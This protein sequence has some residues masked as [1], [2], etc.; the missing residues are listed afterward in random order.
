MHYFIDGYNLLFRLMNADE[1]LQTKREQIII[2]LNAK[3][4]FAKIELSIVFDA[5]YQMGDRTRSHFDHI[6]ILFTAQGESADE[7]I[8]DEIKNSK[9][10]NQETVVT[11][12][13]T[14]AW[15]ARRLS[16]HSQSIES[17]ISWLNKL[18]QKKSKEA[19]YPK[20]TVEPIKKIF[21]VG[22]GEEKK[23]VASHVPSQQAS[24]GDCLEYYERV[25]EERYQ[26]NLKEEKP[27]E[28]KARKVPPR[29]K[30]KK[31]SPFETESSPVNASD[32]M[33]R[34][35]QIFE[36]KIKDT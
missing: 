34:W 10:P 14:L 12:D 27:K 36:T 13:K 18:Y 28:K 15:H 3:A 21:K 25:F 11:S 2:D 17:F 6:E 16:A 7:Y 9:K 8:L 5:A 24:P 19:K 31:S 20:K 30:K 35:L 32:E 4:S 1:N 26:K 23:G 33:T 22:K 29:Q